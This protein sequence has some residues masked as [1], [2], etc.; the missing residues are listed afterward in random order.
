MLDSDK[1]VPARKLHDVIKLILTIL[2]NPS[3]EN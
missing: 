2:K 1:W 3:G